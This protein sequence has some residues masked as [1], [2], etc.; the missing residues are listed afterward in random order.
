MGILDW[1]GRL[2]RPRLTFGLAIGL[3][4]Y[5]LLLVLFLGSLLRLGVGA[6][7]RRVALGGY[8]ALLLVSAVRTVDPASRR[9]YGT[10][11]FGSHDMLRMTRVTGE[12]CG[13]GQDQLA[14]SLEFTVLQPLTDA[15]VGA[16][17]ASAPTPTIVLPDSTSWIFLDP[18]A[19]GRRHFAYRLPSGAK[20]RVLEHREVF[21][22]ANRP[23]SAYYIALPYGDNARA[24]RELTPLYEFRDERRFARH[25]YWISVYRMTARAPVQQ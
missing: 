25:G 22:G 6:V 15:A 4:V 11:A 14:Y 2:R 9:L 12:C 24:M 7:V 18:P 5:A 3:V 23:A 21:Q 13:F 17:E 16:I 10:F 1:P 8:A 20:P 19:S